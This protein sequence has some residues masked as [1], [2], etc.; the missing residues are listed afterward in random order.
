MTEN[1]FAQP[2][3]VI[4]KERPLEAG[5]PAMTYSFPPHSVTILEMYRE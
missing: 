5:S 2:D 3:R 1:T 4:I